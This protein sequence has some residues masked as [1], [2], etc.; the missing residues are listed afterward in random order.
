MTRKRRYRMSTNEREDLVC[1]TV[2][3]PTVA[4]NQET[5]DDCK[6]GIEIQ[7]IV[8][9]KLNI[10]KT[11]SVVEVFNR[12][13]ENVRTKTCDL[14]SIRQAREN[15][16]DY[17]PCE[18]LRVNDDPPQELIDKMKGPKQPKAPTMQ[19]FEEAERKRKLGL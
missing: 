18:N 4:K 6:G 15:P 16:S 19:E 7:N 1:H 13:R 5:F 9:N 11:L 17:L 3:A 10:N 14:S 8:Y 2:D 12:R